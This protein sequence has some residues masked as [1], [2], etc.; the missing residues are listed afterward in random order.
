MNLAS[1]GEIRRDAAQLLR[2]PQRI[3]VSEAAARYLRV[4]TPGG[5]VGPWSRETFPYMVEP[6]DMTSSRHVTGV[7]FVGPSQSGKTFSLIGGRIAY[8]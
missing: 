3:S 5:F 6:L 8:E 4:G 7:V 2:P 1:A